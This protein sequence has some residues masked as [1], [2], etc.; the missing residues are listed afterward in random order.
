MAACGQVFVISYAKPGFPGY[1]AAR[2]AA[3]LAALFPQVRALVLDDARLAALCVER[4]LECPALPHD[5]DPDDEHRR[6][7]GWLCL[8]VFG[9]GVDAVFT[10][11]AYGDGFALALTAC[12]QAPV[13]HVCVDRA[14]LQVPISGTRARADPHALRAFLPAPVYAGFVERVCLLGGESSGKTALCAALAAHFATVWQ[15]EFGR[16]LWERKGGA[17]VFDDMLT[18][19]RTQVARE[20]AMLEQ[21][22]RWL[23]CDTSPLTTLFYSEALFGRADA[24]LAQL[25]ARPYEHVVLCAPDIPFVQDGTR[26]DAAFRAIQHAW[27]RDQL[28]RRGVDYVEV[29]GPLAQRVATVA[30]RLGMIGLT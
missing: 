28:A 5:D 15:P 6:F 3:W 18:I 23:F 29:A 26:Q 20:Q 7:C 12:F 22:T 10:S 24:A 1:G 4:G 8:H 9:T 25:A 16:E 27:Y 13:R 21:A 30:Q 2:R 11:E 17:L 14:R 19:G